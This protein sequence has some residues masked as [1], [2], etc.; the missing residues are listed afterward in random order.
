[1]PLNSDLREF[2]ALLNSNGVEY[3]VVGAFA[4][5]YHGYPRYTADLDLL[6][7]PTSCAI[8]VRFREHGHHRSRPSNA[9]PGDSLG[10]KPN[11][12]DLLTAISGV[13]FDEVWAA[14]CEAD[15][16]RVRTSFIGLDELIR[17]KESTGR[18]RDLGDAEELRKRY[19]S[20]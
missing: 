17:N 3:V 15:P 14:R 6:V 1:M 10:V 5:A 13:N 11:C 20:K 18:T 7:R 2:L 12:I 8:G 16:D 4:V 9:K 19:P